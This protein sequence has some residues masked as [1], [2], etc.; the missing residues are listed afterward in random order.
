[1]AGPTKTSDPEER[2]LTAV[3]DALFAL[4]R[5]Q[6]E[7]RVEL[8]EGAYSQRIEEVAA[9]VNALAEKLASQDAELRSTQTPLAEAAYRAALLE[10]ITETTLDG[11][12]VADEN[13]AAISMNRR[14]LEMWHIPE[15]LGKPSKDTHLL[16]FV[17]DQLADPEQFQTKVEHLYS[18]PEEKSR[19]VLTFKDGRVFDRFSSPLVA[20]GGQLLGRV[21]Y[22]RDITPSAE[23]EREREE[24]T[25]LQAELIE[26]QR[27]ALRELSTPL[28]PISA[29]IV[30]MP[31]IG[32]ID[33]ERAKLI[34]QKLVEG[35]SDRK[36]RVALLDLTGVSVLDTQVADTLLKATRSCRLV[37]AEVVLT[38]VQP[39]MAQT[40]VKLGV[41]LGDIA[42]RSTLQAGISYALEPDPSTGARS[43]EAPG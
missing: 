22:F 29:D 11:I 42:T 9:G 15:E 23:L 14:F 18:H 1:M 4:L 13:G 20:K 21:W 38:G 6:L 43:N 40:L 28:V 5:G 33:S 7:V 36:A 34:L 35:V 39:E 12:L 30:A 2:A 31:I 27:R 41:D 32:E 8:E 19:D 3:A 16:H 26:A 37:G 10:S 17:L 24:R 25:R